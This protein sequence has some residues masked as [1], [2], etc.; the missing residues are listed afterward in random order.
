[1]TCHDIITS[2]LYIYHI[3]TSTDIITH[4]SSSLSVTCHDIITSYLYIYHIITSTDIIFHKSSSLSVSWLPVD[5]SM[6]VINQVYFLC[7]LLTATSQLFP[8]QLSLLVFASN[9][10]CVMCTD[11]QELYIYT[12]T[13][14]CIYICVCVIV[15]VGT[16]HICLPCLSL[17]K[18]IVECCVCIYIY[19]YDRYHC[20]K[21]GSIP[22]TDGGH[23]Y[24]IFM[25]VI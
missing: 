23:I 17:V 8:L 12:H 6:H 9:F 20:F 24:L 21:Y 25:S 3:I 10:H 2:Y 14:L 19:I 22:K 1:M 15:F 7:Y 5:L 13:Y 11:L 4:R 16:T 18:T